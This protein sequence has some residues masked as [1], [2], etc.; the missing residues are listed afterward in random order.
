[1]NFAAGCFV[2][3]LLCALGAAGFAW[4]VAKGLGWLAVHGVA[5]GAAILIAV[6]AFAAYSLFRAN[7]DG[8]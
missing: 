1:M 4:A 6:L 8:L 7:R 5:P 2:V 3:L